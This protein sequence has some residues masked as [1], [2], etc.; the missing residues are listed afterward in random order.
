MSFSKLFTASDG[1][2]PFLQILIGIIVGAIGMFIYVK[3]WKPKI[4]FDNVESIA[5][6]G[7]SQPLPAPNTNAKIQMQPQQQPPQQPMQQTMQQPVQSS[8]GNVPQ[9][10]IR[11][12]PPMMSNGEAYI[13]IQHMQMPSMPPL[14][15][16]YEAE[17]EPEEETDDEDEEPE[18]GRQL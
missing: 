17:E 18:Y 9:G 3:F 8:N 7:V 12:S 5:G 15:T 2:I 11:M 10:T 14:A 13:E 6:I 1:K 16:I 4:L